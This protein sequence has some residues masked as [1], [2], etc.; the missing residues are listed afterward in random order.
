MKLDNLSKSQLKFL[1]K[2]LISSQR[3]GYDIGKLIRMEP[4]RHV[5]IDD[6][7]IGSNVVKKQHFPEIKK[8]EVPIFV[9]YGIN[10]IRPR[11]FSIFNTLKLQLQQFLLHHKPHNVNFF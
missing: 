1:C 3:G 4:D 8:Q 11:D 5:S 6:I 10:T 7:N 2:K 9:T